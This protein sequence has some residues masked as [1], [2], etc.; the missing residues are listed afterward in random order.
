VREISGACLWET[1][2]K[3]WRGAVGGTP[4]GP[5][6]RAD[7]VSWDRTVRCTVAGVRGDG[8]LFSP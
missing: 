5:L 2:D 6:L 4:L 1:G 7:Q 3:R 8:T